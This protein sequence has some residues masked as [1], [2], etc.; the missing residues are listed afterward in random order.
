MLVVHGWMDWL[1]GDFSLT[2]ERRG[3]EGKEENQK[4]KAQQQT[5]A[6]SEREK[7]P[8]REFRAAGD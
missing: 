6:T 3:G 2:S 5:N 7:F 1:I 8:S 4:A